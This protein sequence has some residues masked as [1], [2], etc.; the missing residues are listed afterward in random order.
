MDFYPNNG[1]DQPGCTSVILAK[2]C[3]HVRAI[4]LFTE[5]INS[6]CQFTAYECDSYDNF[7]KGECFSCKNN[8]SLSCA[9]M[10][11]HA[12]KSLALKE[13]SVLGKSITDSL[14]GSKFFISTGDRNPFCRKY[15]LLIN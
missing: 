10:G 7:I 9:I 12:D 11:Y 5:S 8:N 1:D 15:F 3:N 4:K 2:F 6:N 13:R 14:I